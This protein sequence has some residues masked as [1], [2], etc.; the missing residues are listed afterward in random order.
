M[1]ISCPIQSLDERLGGIDRAITFLADAGFDAYDFSCIKMNDPTYFMNQEN[2]R[3]EIRRYKDVADR[4]GIVCN[5][6]HAPFPSSVGDA[7]KNEIIFEQ[8]V[9]SMEGAAILGAK[10]IVVHPKQHLCYAEHA[11][12]LKEMNLEF[13]SR[14]IPYAEKFGIK[15]ATENMWQWNKHA[16]HPIDSTCSRA[17][18]FCEYIDMINSPYL[19]GCLDIGHVFLTGADLGDFIRTMGKDRLQALHVHDNDF[20]HDSHTLPYLLNIDFAEMTTALREIGYEGDLTFEANAFYRNIPDALLP[21]AARYMC[22]VGKYLASQ[23][24]NA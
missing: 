7:E 20:L 18:E 1:L 19:V 2:W 15:I 8:I 11:A 21:A 24:Q 10:C 13:Y 3:D 6:A 16:K 22:E 12:E 9:R 17:P 4:A 5:Q 23:I 14:L